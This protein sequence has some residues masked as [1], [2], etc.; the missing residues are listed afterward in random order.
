MGSHGGS[1]SSFVREKIEDYHYDPLTMTMVEVADKLIDDYPDWLD[2]A[3]YESIKRI[4]R[5]VLQDR[6]VDKEYREQIVKSETKL[7]KARDKNRIA[8][9]T[10]REHARLENAIGEFSSAL[11]EVYEDYGTK[12][13][14]NL[15]EFGVIED[16]S[17]HTGIG[18]M[19]FTDIH[20]NE[21]I[22]L[23]HNKYDF[24]VLSSR[25]RQYVHDC[26]NWFK[27]MRV[28]K[29]LCAFTGD[30]LNSDRRLD[31]MLNQATNRSKAALLL[32]HIIVQAL[33]EIRTHG[34]SIDVVSVLGNE[35]RIGQELGFSDEVASEN[36]DLIVMGGV[37]QIIA[38][39]GIDN[40][41]FKSIDQMEVVVK[42]G[43]QNWL[44]THDIAKITDN[45]HKTQ[46]TIG[47][48]HLQGTPIDYIIAGHIHIS[49]THGFAARAGSLSGSNTYNERALSLFSR[50]QANAYV[51]KDGR[52]FVQILD[53]QD[54][55][56][57]NYPGYNINSELE[58]Y[59]AKSARKTQPSKTI[60]QIIC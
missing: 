26:I 51:V 37:K 12:L 23:P 20:A 3:S 22:N 1:I 55:H 44:I 45:Q 33:T 6:Q 50:A 34:F 60:L 40:I 47:R 46:S 41:S 29:V 19:Q 21:L 54:A 14:E 56:V 53:H 39:S 58:A 31:E 43:D 5:M 59:N 7:Q 48:F 42:V 28:S 10:F 57:K 52:R 24:N 9:K 2:K 8:N 11:I 30:L 17:D 36:Y 18:I 32:Q 49:H 25:L 16:D 15:P 27:T 13:A 38:A 35:S 4:V